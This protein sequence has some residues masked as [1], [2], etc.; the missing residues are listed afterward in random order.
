MTV[1]LAKRRKRNEQQHVTP[2]KGNNMSSANKTKKPPRRIHFL[3]YV[4]D[5]NLPVALFAFLQIFD[6]NLLVLSLIHTVYLTLSSYFYV[7]TY[8][9]RIYFHYWCFFFFF[10]S[11]ISLIADEPHHYHP[12]CGH[13]GSSHLSPVHACFH[14]FISVPMAR[15][16]FETSHI[17]EL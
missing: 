4:E 11:L 12:A 17:Y 9:T 15:C 10:F 3:D 14:K 16:T 6:P 1:A 2:E 7:R 13:K 5:I 8:I